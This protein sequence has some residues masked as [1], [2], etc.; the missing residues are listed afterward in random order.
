MTGEQVDRTTHEAGAD[1]RD[2]SV[3]FVSSGWPSEERPEESIFVA[4]QADAL[5]ALG[6]RV[7]VVHYVGQMRPSN[8]LRARRE[9]TRR[10][11]SARYDLIHAHFGQSA[12][13]I[14]RSDLPLVHTFYGSDLI[15]V[16][17]DDG[18]YT[19]RG[20]VLR[21]VSR[22]GSKRAAAV[23]VLSKRL[24]RELPADVPFSVL[25]LGVDLDVFRPGDKLDARRRAGMDPQRRYVLF[26]GRPSQPVKRL[27]LARRAID[28]L[29]QP[30]AELV[31]LEG[32]PRSD[33]A[34][35]M[36]ACDAL[37]V[38][39]KHESGPLIVKEAL[40]CDLPVVSVDV[41]DVRE[42]IESLPG[43]VLCPD[44]HPETISRAVDGVLR[45][46]APFRGRH[47]VEH[48]AESVLVHRLLEIYR[49]V[50]P[51]R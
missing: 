16:V 12:L 42:W 39:S 14:P 2:L 4:R 44:D 38:T 5:R 20:R 37:V 27:D 31:V 29:P 8:Y 49:S 34:T 9:A 36:V 19:Q 17:G 15:G 46:P 47:A 3:L 6:A 21:L 40:A 41:G 22:W 33:V 51:S 45:A 7:D 1:A 30:G 18:R 10:L 28:L 23:V 48:L 24:G 26:A 50:L 25:P 11:A 35:A 13:A 32:K 43:C